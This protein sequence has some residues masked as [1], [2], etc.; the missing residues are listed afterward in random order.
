MYSD[1]DL[2][3]MAHILHVP[4]RDICMKDEFKP[5]IDSN[6]IINLQ[7]SRDPVTHDNNNGTHWTSLYIGPNYEAYY[8]D[9]FG[10]PPP[11]EVM[12][13][14]Q[15][16]NMFINRHQIQNINTYYCGLYSLMFLY[17]INRYRNPLKAVRVYQSKFSNDTRK[18]LMVLKRL[19]CEA[20]GMMP[21]KSES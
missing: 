14:L 21:L 8:L 10:M 3:E 19:Y 1:K 20:T 4:I 11:L 9:P 6:Y 15:G 17:Y 2:M 18:N 7:S 12:N 16:Y 13:K 5:E